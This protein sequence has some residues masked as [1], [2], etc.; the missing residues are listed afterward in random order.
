MSS[1]LSL[2]RRGFTLVELL[3]V[4]AIIGI[5]VGMILPAVQAAR[6]A[7]RRTTCLN[8]VKNVVLA[9]VNYETSNSRYPAAVATPGD[10][11]LVRILPM[12]DQKGMYDNY[13]S[14][15]DTPANTVTA[16]ASI[17]SNEL[18]IFRCASASTG[19]FETDDANA[20][21]QFT[22]HYTGNSGPANAPGNSGSGGF[23]S[24]Q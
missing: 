20:A 24:F 23:Q 8:N 7:A 13:R 6:E 15:S 1:K 17:A 14:S 10:S 21:G 12:L 16:L 22:S 9:C 3:V 19:D 2:R 11:F 5:L 4:I 18:E